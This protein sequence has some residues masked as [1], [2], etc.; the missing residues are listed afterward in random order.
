MIEGD[1]IFGTIVKQPVKTLVNLKILNIFKNSFN[2]QS[3]Y[4]IVDYSE[5]VAN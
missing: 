5:N 1:I 4:V 3:Y 2:Y